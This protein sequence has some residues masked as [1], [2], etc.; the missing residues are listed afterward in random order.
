[1]QFLPKG[2]LGQNAQ[3]PT[4]LVSCV[5][6]SY[7]V[8]PGLVQQG[9]PLCPQVQRHPR[10]FAEPPPVWNNHQLSAIVSTAVH[11]AQVAIKLL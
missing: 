2:S 11:E 7:V 5:S 10:H 6:C 8:I 3:V 4:L 9:H 1:M